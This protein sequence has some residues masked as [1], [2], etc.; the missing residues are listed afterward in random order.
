MSEELVN[1]KIGHEGEDLGNALQPLLKM[2]CLTGIGVILAN[3]KH[4]FIP[5][6]TFK[7][8]SKLVFALFLPCLIFC[9]LGGSISYERL[10]E[11]WF[12]PVNVILSTALG[13]MLGIIV[14]AICRPPPEFKRFTIATAGFGNTGNLLLA[15]VGSVCHTEKNPF[16]DKC[17]EAGVAYVSLSQGI[18]VILLYTFVYHMMEPPPEYY[19]VVDDE[20]QQ[21]QE[22]EDERTLSKTN[23]V[24]TPLLVQAEWLGI[25]NETG[26]CKT[27][28][29]ARIFRDSDN[30]SAIPEENAD[31]GNARESIQCFAEPRVVKKIRAIAE[32]TPVWNIFQ[33]PT[34]ASLLAIIIGTVPHLKTLFFG[35]DAPFSFITDSMNILAGAVVPCVMLI[36]GGVLAEGPNE[37]KLG[38]RTM[39]GIIVARLVVLPLIGIGVVALANKMNLLVQND[40][41]FKFVLL[42]QYTSPTAILLGAIASLRGYAVSE[43]S[44][45][46]FWQHLFALLSFSLYIVIYFKMIN[47]I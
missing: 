35:Y 44:A 37:S 19:E 42:L 11:W 12:I 18:S 21:Q 38:V 16:G 43:A 40:L 36:L 10:V 46:L 23:N 25:E 47:H 39:I 20:E 22:Q 7:L 32:K 24:S 28:L 26:V 17:R 31:A 27:P 6:A 1:G 13:C 30:S 29:I 34:V 8:L 45:L 41:M 15:M 4:Q 2:L 3:P 5:K 14:F 33:P 9:D